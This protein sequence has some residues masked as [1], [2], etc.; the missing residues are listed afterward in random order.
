MSYDPS[1][2]QGTRA[3]QIDINSLSIL[4]DDIITHTDSSILSRNKYFIE[5]KVYLTTASGVSGYL[6]WENWS[7]FAFMG[8]MTR[9]N[10]AAGAGTAVD[11]YYAGANTPNTT[12][13]RTLQ[14][15]G[16]S[17]LTRTSFRPFWR[18]E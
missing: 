16:A 13:S 10:D 12:L 7:G 15:S 5:C 17:F 18:I 14:T 3:V 6:A 8:G 9:S 4:S 1:Q 11:D 2:A